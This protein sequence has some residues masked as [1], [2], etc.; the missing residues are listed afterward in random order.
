MLSYLKSSFFLA[1]CVFGSCF[2]LTVCV[3]GSCL[4]FNRLCLGLLK[5][6]VCV[7]IFFFFFF[8]LPFVCLGFLFY[9]NRLCVWVLFLFNRLC[10]WVLFLFNRLCVWILFL[11]NCLCVWVLFQDVSNQLSFRFFFCPFFSLAFFLSPTVFFSS[12]SLTV[13][14][15]GAFS[16][17]FLRLHFRSG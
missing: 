1:V 15:A 13:P 2:F 12:T 16:C 8:F 9:F 7:W 10:V 14:F 17:L 3:F 5:K 4:Y 6:I 11:F